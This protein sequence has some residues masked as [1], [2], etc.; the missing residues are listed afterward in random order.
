MRLIIIITARKVNM[1]MRRIFFF[2][3]FTA[4]TFALVGCNRHNDKFTLLDASDTGASFVN[5]VI[6]SDSINIFDFENIYNGGGV[7]IGDFNADGLPDIYF[8]G[9]MVPNKLFL[10]QG[11]LKFKDITQVSGTDGAGKWSRGA[12]VIDING[13]NLQDI[14]VCTTAYS[15]P[16]RRRNILYIN[17]G[18]NKDGIPVFEDQAKAY[19]LDDTTHTTMAYFFDYDRDGDLDVYLAVNHIVEN[20]Y[21]NVFQPRTID[22]THPSCGRLY[23]NDFDSQ[24]QHPFY[25]DVS[26]PAGIKYEGYTHAVNIFDANNDGWP[27]IMEA[28]DYI[29]NNVLYINN[30]DGTFTDSITSYF[31]HTAANSMGSDAIDLNNDGLDDVIEVDMAPQDN[32]RKKMFMQPVNYT[33]YINSQ[34]FDYQLQY[35]RN[36]V[37]AN[38]GNTV[39]ENDS[40]QHPVFADIGYFSGVAETDWSWCPLIADFDQDGLRDI[41]FTNGFPKDITDHD[42]STYRKQAYQL[43]AKKEMLAE[44]PEV[45]IHNYAYKNNGNFSFAD[46]TFDWG[47]DAPSFSSGAA[48]A[49]LDNDGDL[50]IIINNMNDPA[51]IY[52]NNNNDDINS[53]AGFISCTL[54]GNKQNKTG[55][56]ARVTL[57]ANDIIQSITQNPYRGYISTVT[58][59]IHFGTSNRNADSLVVDWPDGMRQTVIAPANNSNIVLRY[60]DAKPVT[61]PSVSGSPVSTPL[62]TNITSA[63]GIQYNHYQRDFIDFNIQKLLPHK[64]S[65]YS[66]GMAAGD[67]NGDGLDD[68]VITAAP[69]NAPTILTQNANGKFTSKLLYD[70]ATA[71]YKQQDERG[72]L[73][74]DADNDRDLDLL[75]TSGGYS[76]LSND[77][78]FADMFFINDGKGN[79]IARHDLLPK[80]NTSKL[81]IR[82]CDYDKDGD[83]DLFISGRVLPHYYPKPVSS[84]IYQNNTTNGQITFEDVTATVAPALGNIGMVC[85]ALFTD[86]NN[87]GWPDLMLAGELMPLTILDNNKG[88]FAVS[89]VKGL[90]QFSGWWNSL[91]AD[92]FDSDGDVDYIAGNLGT[93][94]YFRGSITQPMH[95]YA[96][97]YDS[98]G[99]Y[100]AIPSLYFKSTLE[101]NAKIEEYPA[102]GRDDMVKQVLFTR[103]KFPTYKSFATAT[104]DSLIP[105]PLRAKSL[106]LKANTFQSM[107]LQN[108]GSEG[109]TMKPLPA[110]AQYSSLNGMLADDFNRDGLTDLFVNTNDYSA[111]PNTGRYDA[112]N[113]LVM[114]GDGK[115]NFSPISMTTAGVTISGNGKSLVKLRSANGSYLVAAAQNRGPLL[116]FS[117]HYKPRQV[118]VE[119]YDAFAIVTNAD[120]SKH[121]IEL[122]YGMSFLSAG[123]RFIT[124]PEDAKDCTIYQYN[125]NKRYVQ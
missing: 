32:Y 84:F 73:L 56:G 91:I 5:S 119:P 88:Q 1:T 109:F 35:I 111:D 124:L 113:G 43:T 17:K 52:R 89:S 46:K 69:G 29:S 110:M 115:G 70:S 2:T 34:M 83:L 54:E 59:I 122:Y 75:I 93:N 78:S 66:P 27:D 120:G 62:F 24:R 118:T 82:A 30:K 19:G 92:D 81:C 21:P 33:T 44:I 95:I 79:F 18:N 11:D 107:Y 99:S 68:L 74:F 76:Y 103:G 45:K 123:S 23:R 96:A 8:T 112:L 36:M 80:N 41:L 102:H 28:N 55:I 50:D 4:G 26:K 90:S 13:D 10:N 57:Y 98:N 3:L 49:D 85:D 94:S 53:H 77:S 106:V 48:Y 100:D 7:G 86:Y 104:M 6:E 31:K 101:L 117:L 60:A 87:D 47:F 61:E 105:A 9:S 39:G 64:L 20:D 12:A 65:E 67:I 42:F 97:D 51:F 22:G 116:L 25:T 16:E 108:N 125:G 14:Y 72:I 58:T 121:K 63:A 40:I 15:D 37:Q 71:G 38:M 114:L